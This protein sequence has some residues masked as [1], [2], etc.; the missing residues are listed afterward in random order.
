MSGKVT[1]LENICKGCSLCAS[2]CPK[3]IMAP[4]MEKLNGN[5]YHP[6]AVRDPEKCIACGMCAM[7]C[8]DSAIK[9]ERE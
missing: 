2:V 4:D 5:G 6:A 7:I 8:P 9:V 1:I 3:K